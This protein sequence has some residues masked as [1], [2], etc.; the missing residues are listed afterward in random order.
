MTI[1]FESS[2]VLAWLF[3]EPDA[4]RVL[5]ALTVEGDI[6]AS[7]LTLVECD[8]VLVRAAVSGRVAEAE[9]ERRRSALGTVARRWSIC[10]LTPEQIDRA[11][12]PFPREP[13]RTLD[14]LHLAAALQFQRE[15][16]DVTVLS[17]DERI[18]TNAHALGL[19]LM[20]A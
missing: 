18:R 19:P 6:V 12:R 5:S 15:L 11:R 1:Y 9:A 3:D 14:A 17:L 10:H 13:L 2:A 20:P 4:P 16:G 8:R 7:V